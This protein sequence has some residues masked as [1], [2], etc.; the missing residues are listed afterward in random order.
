[1]TSEETLHGL[2][3]ELDRCLRNYRAKREQ[4]TKLQS[5]LKSTKT[6]LTELTLKLDSTVKDYEEQKVSRIKKIFLSSWELFFASI[7][8][9]KLLIS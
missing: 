1:M 2:K 7:S 8:H 6:K 5:E 3:S 4:V 9:F